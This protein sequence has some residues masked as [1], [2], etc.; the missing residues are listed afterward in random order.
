MLHAEKKSGLTAKK[1]IYEWSPILEKAGRTYTYWK[2]RHHLRKLKLPIPPSLQNI[3]QELG[4]LSTSNSI[5]YIRHKKQKSTN[6]KI[7]FTF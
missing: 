3:Q 4:I 5:N 6:T 1:G 7:T 2:A